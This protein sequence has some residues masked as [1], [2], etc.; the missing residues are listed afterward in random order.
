MTSTDIFQQIILFIQDLMSNLTIN[1]DA[2]NNTLSLL[3]H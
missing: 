1:Y 3:S 2:V